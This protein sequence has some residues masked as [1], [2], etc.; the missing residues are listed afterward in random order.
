MSNDFKRTATAVA[1]TL[2]LT[3]I[4]TPI[5]S[6]QLSPQRAAQALQ[7]NSAKSTKAQRVAELKPV[8]ANEDRVIEILESE[9]PPSSIKEQR[10]P[11]VESVTKARNATLR[12]IN[13]LEGRDSNSGV[14]EAQ[15]NDRAAAKKVQPPLDRYAALQ[16]AHQLLE[17]D[18]TVLSKEPASKNVHHANALKFLQQARDPVQKEVEAYASVHP[19]VQAAQAQAAA[20]PLPAQAR[21]V[22]PQ[23]AQPQPVPAQP[24]QANPAL[25]SAQRIDDLR[26][27]I[28]HLEHS[29]DMTNAAPDDPQKHRQNTLNALVHARDTARQILAQALKE[30]PTDLAKDVQNDHARDATKQ[31]INNQTGYAAL[32]RIQQYLHNDR[33]VIAREAD[34]PAH[35]RE[36]AL[37]SI[38]QANTALQLQIDDYNRA[39][40]NEKH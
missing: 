33:I 25:S 17:Q 6:A 40:P 9:E 24:A 29:I 34:D 28:P 10:K 5:V 30:S 7:A 4:S 39:H 14:D 37:A 21:P 12:Y 13:D 26:N 11:L 8:I 32:Q 1:S 2:F 3:A 20:A 15:G 31:N 35:L 38:D 36:N 19:E 18:Y 27:V 22:Q 23:P 16:Q